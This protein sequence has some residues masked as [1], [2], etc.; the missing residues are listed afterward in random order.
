MNTSNLKTLTHKLVQINN[1]SDSMK[2]FLFKDGDRYFIKPIE[3]FKGNAQEA[4]KFYI[5]ES[6]VDDVKFCDSPKLM[7]VS[8]KSWHYRLM[9]YVLRSNVPTPKSMQNGCPYFWL[10]IFSILVSPFLFL[11][12]G[13]GSFLLGLP[14]LFWKLIEG[15]ALLTLKAMPEEKA[16]SVDDYGYRGNYDVPILAKAH[17]IH[18]QKRFLPVYIRAKYGIRHDKD[19]EAYNKKVKELIALRD[20]WEEKQS[21]KIDERRKKET[22]LYL[23][24]QEKKKEKDRKNSIARKKREKFWMPFNKAMDKIMNGLEAAMTFDYKRSPIIK[25]TKQFIGLLISLI[26]LAA[27]VVVVLMVGLIII[28]L[29]DGLVFVFATYTTWIFIILGILVALVIVTAIGYLFINWIQS[30]IDKYKIGKKIWYVQLFLYTFA[31]P[32]KYLFLGISGVLFYGIFIP[33]KWVFYDII[34]E[35]IL[36]NLGIF[37]WG[38]MRAFGGIVLGSLGIFGE[39]FGAS[40]KD[41]C[42]GLEWVD[43]ED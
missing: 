37:I 36:L 20:A 34:Y 14:Y 39:Y 22:E 13:F 25:R 11:I 41:Y 35:R 9:K 17:F 30:L 1:E 28:M 33:I 29:I 43:T 27:T 7:R 5:T 40:K 24:S 42:P 2:G 38:L 6:N 12:R 32:I 3:V 18:S 23:I 4:G 8:M 19:P 16:Y 21:I 10:L 31:F 15:V 26:V